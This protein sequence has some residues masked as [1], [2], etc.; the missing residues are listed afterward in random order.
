[1]IKRLILTT[2]VLIGGLSLS[3]ATQS[4][5]MDKGYRIEVAGAPERNAQKIRF[6][7]PDG[8]LI[9]EIP[10]SPD[11]PKW[12]SNNLVSKEKIG[13]MIRIKYIWGKLSR[14][15]RRVVS[16]TEIIDYPAKYEGAYWVLEG[17]PF[18]A[19]ITLYNIK[20]EELFTRSVRVR[21]TGD[22]TD[23][24]PF[25]IA[26]ANN[27]RVMVCAE[28]DSTR[29]VHWV[30]VYDSTGKEILRKDLGYRIGSVEFSPNGD[31]I[32]ATTVVPIEI[33]KEK[34]M[35][36]DEIMQLDSFPKMSQAYLLFLEV[37]TG[38]MKL[39][40]ASGRGW[41]VRFVISSGGPLISGKVLLR[42]SKRGEY[43]EIYLPFDQIPE[44]LSQLFGGEK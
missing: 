41:R 24:I 40:K 21:T 18:T 28:L 31:I 14:D 23:Y 17:R 15:K 6:I 7:N 37:D 8:K 26:A 1:M 20:G 42:W 11:G 22:E 27:G 36:P 2:L 30:V 5:S 38:R 16:C 25:E 32:G 39:V 10:Y 4:K 19:E 13:E 9:K 34:R 3:G 43:G 29:D 35:T 33:P 12:E 44:D